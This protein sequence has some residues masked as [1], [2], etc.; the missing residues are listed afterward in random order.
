MSY[1][2]WSCFAAFKEVQVK[3]R[4]RPQ[5]RH[6]QRHHQTAE[7]REVQVK[8]ATLSTAELNLVDAPMLLKSQFFSAEICLLLTLAD[9]R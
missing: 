2:Y 4:Y 6:H 1:L 3:H 8:N 7:T 9:D 5:D